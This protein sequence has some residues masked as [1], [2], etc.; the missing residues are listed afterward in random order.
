VDGNRSGHCHMVG[1]DANSVE[2]SSYSTT[3]LGS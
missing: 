2:P 3:V 1:F